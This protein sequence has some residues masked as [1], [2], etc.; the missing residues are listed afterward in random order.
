MQT[1]ALSETLFRLAVTNSKWWTK[2]INP[3]IPK[4]N[5]YTSCSKSSKA[6]LSQLLFGERTGNAALLE[7]SVIA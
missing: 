2:C 1:A 4:I 7:E 6:E 5:I 3:V